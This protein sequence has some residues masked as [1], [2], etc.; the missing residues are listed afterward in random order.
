[1]IKNG[2]RFV[3]HR[4]TLYNYIQLGIY[5]TQSYKMNNI[6][7]AMIGKIKNITTQKSIR[8][9]DNL[10]IEFGQY[11]NHSFDPNVKV[12]NNK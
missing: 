6:V 3:S 5:K 7:R 10:N 11:I 2:H 4:I 9:G 1:M 8:I 12:L